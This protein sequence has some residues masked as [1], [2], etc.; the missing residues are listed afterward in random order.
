M[1]MGCCIGEKKKTTPPIQPKREETRDL[2]EETEMTV[3][4]NIAARVEKPFG[5]EKSFGRT[6]TSKQTQRLRLLLRDVEEVFLHIDKPLSKDELII[7]WEEATKKNEGAELS[8][9]SMQLITMTVE[10]AIETM[11]ADH[12]GMISYAEFKT[13]EMGGM[14]GKDH[15]GDLRSHIEKTVE[16]DPNFL[17]SI[18][19]LFQKADKDKNG[20]LDKKEFK[21]L[22]KLLQEEHNL[23]ITDEN[24]ATMFKEMDLDD[25]EQ[26]D[27]YEFLSYQLGRRKRPV[28]LLVYD[29]SK[30]FSKKYSNFFLGSTFEA[31]YHT[32]VLFGGKEY[33][34]G[35]SIFLSNPPCT[36]QF[37]DPL[38]ESEMVNLTPSE[39]LEGYHSFKFD[40]SLVGDKELMEYISKKLVHKYTRDVYDVF[41]HNCNNFSNELAEFLCGNPLPDV[42]MD[43]PARFMGTRLG[44]IAR[45]FLNKHLGGFAGQKGKFGIVGDG[46]IK[47][48][49][50][51]DMKMEDGFADL[52]PID[53]IP[54]KLREDFA[55]QNLHDK[56]PAK[57]VGF[58]AN[59]TDQ[60]QVKAV[61]LQ[62]YDCKKGALVRIDNVD[63]EQ[64]L[65]CCV[66]GCVPERG[67]IQLK[68]VKTVER[69]Q[70]DT[71]RS[72]ML[73]RMN[74]CRDRKLEAAGITDGERK[75]EAAQAGITDADLKE[76]VKEEADPK[77]SV[78]EEARVSVTSSTPEPQTGDAPRESTQ[79]RGTAKTKPKAKSRRPTRK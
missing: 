8:E 23:Q 11:D 2:E 20:V 48:A 41:T 32:G 15:W 51:D 21:N 63:N 29:V 61:D 17:S 39:Q 3:P 27:Y 9:E 18:L 33:W 30:G 35:G 53:I 22:F 54:A 7:L 6:L 70:R 64:L 38:L 46:D 10:M 72:D 14:E 43:L 76:S 71:I 31:I 57:I 37:G 24:I 73:K 28:E 69:L 40:F 66:K 12:S 75:S 65:K 74:S 77:E 5:A 62:F 34:Y 19:T 79:T 60:Y 1:T 59:E 4:L 78:K 25:D 52:L 67:S 36:K 47:E 44:K 26:V 49:R 55:K 56:V 42:I 45:P 58:H 68:P 16:D 50:I 13:W